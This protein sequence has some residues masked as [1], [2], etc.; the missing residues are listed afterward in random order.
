VLFPLSAAQLVLARRYQFESWARL[1][2]HVQI[3]TA[4]AWVPEPAPLDEPRPDHFLRLPCLTGAGDEASDRVA[5]TALLAGHPGLTAASIHVAAACA[6]V[7]Q[8]RWLLAAD[9]S[10]AARPGGPHRWSPLLYQAYAR[11]DPH[12]GLAATLGANDDHLALLFEF[13]LGR[14]DGGPWHRLLGDALESPTVMLRNL[15]WWA[16][17]HDQRDWV[18][19]LAAHSVDIESP[20]AEQRARLAGH[21]TPAAEALVNG[22]RELAAQLGALGA[23]NPRLSPPDAFVAAALAGDA[24]EVAR[25]DP[26]VIAAVR[27]A[28]PGLVTWAAS[29]GAPDA[30]ELL[31]SA[32]FDVNSLGRSDVPANDPWHTALHVAAGN[33]NLQLASKLLDLG[34]KPAPARPA[35][36]FHAA[37]LGAR[38]GHQSLIDLLSR[39]PGAITNTGTD[40]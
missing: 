4:R 29:Q 15:L 38:F 9:N 18:A 34:A 5:A 31:A 16:V 36:R 33:G 30:V 19:L 2:R 39:Q 11:H 20:L 3:V 22:H 17:A 25:T 10:L 37:G 28:R 40:K 24:D 1:H 12:P 13:G 6:D 35:P 21:R 7:V 32:G 26:A 23:G 14:G 27:E 8:V